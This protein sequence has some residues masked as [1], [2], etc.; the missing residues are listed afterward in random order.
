VQ[1]VRRRRPAAAATA[2]SVPAT[3]RQPRPD[4]TIRAWS[5]DAPKPPPRPSKQELYEAEVV[6]FINRLRASNSDEYRRKIAER[7]LALQAADGAIRNMTF[8]SDGD[9]S[10]FRLYPHA[11]KEAK[12]MLGWALRLLHPKKVMG[13]VDPH[14]P[15]RWPAWAFYNDTRV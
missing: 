10:H 8:V 7:E 4:R 6:A 13:T 9:Q 15:K 1:V 3:P 11:T 12:G 5:V 14:F 2:P